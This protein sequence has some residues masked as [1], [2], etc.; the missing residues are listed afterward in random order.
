MVIQAERPQPAL[1]RPVLERPAPPIFGTYYPPQPA[2]R[3]RERML[4]VAF[5]LAVFGFGSV[6]GFEYAG[7]EITRLRLGAATAATSTRPAT[8]PYSVQ[9]SAIQQD[10][11]VLVRWDRDSEAVKTALYGVLTITEGAASKEV[12]LDFPELRNGTVLYHRV[13]QQVGFRLDLY[14]KENRIFTESLTLRFPEQ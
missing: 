1:E 10:Q 14:F 4:W 11:S 8:D 6:V 3:W 13:S 9:L 12:K 5:T 7:G 2:R